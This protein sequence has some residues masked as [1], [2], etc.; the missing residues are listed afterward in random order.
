MALSPADATLKKKNLIIIL[1]T[2][3]AGPGHFKGGGADYCGNYAANFTLKS[4]K[5]VSRIL[6]L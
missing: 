6:G 5:Y 3:G 4:V 1:L 2:S